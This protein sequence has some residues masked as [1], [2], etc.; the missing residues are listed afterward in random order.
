[1][2]KTLIVLLSAGIILGACSKQ[3]FRISSQIGSTGEETSSHFFVGG[4][5]QSDEINAASICGG[6]TKVAS[7]ETSLSPINIMLRIVTMG[8]YVPQKYKVSCIR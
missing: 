1:M 3:T 4:I 7:V 5:A 8:L 6:G 2:H